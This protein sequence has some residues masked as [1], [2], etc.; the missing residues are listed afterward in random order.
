MLT[1]QQKLENA[2]VLLQRSSHNTVGKEELG[3]VLTSHQESL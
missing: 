3:H 2:A 1:F